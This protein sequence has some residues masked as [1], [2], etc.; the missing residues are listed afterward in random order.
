MVLAQLT[1]TMGG[2]RLASEDGFRIGLLIGCGVALVAAAVAGAKPALRASRG[3][4]AVGS[5]QAEGQVPARA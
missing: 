1:V 4:E 2:H 5:D 3:D